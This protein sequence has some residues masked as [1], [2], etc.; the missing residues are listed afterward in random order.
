MILSEFEGCYLASMATDKVWQVRKEVKKMEESL[1]NLRKEISII[2]GYEI[3]MRLNESKVRLQM[4]RKER[5]IRNREIE[6]IA[7]KVAFESLF[8]SK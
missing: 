4:L 3:S 7:A 8:T 2:I 6:K 5:R 1:P